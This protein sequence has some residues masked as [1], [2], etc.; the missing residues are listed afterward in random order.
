MENGEERN[1]SNSEIVPNGLTYDQK[2]IFLAFQHRVQ[3]ELIN[4]KKLGEQEEH[5]KTWLGIFWFSSHR[6]LTP[7]SALEAQFCFF[8]YLIPSLVYF[9]VYSF[10]F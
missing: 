5:L 7:N 6:D 3:E 8:L 10:L 1:E 2:Q 9:V 4:A